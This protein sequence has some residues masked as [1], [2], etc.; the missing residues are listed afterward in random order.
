MCLEPHRLSLVR[1]TL[2]SKKKMKMKMR[3]ILTDDPRIIVVIIS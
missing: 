3:K 2:K 1:K